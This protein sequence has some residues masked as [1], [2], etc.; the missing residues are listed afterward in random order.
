MKHFQIPGYADVSLQNRQYFDFYK[1][2]LGS[3]PNL[4]AML[5]HSDTGLDAYL[6]FHDHKQSLTIPEKEIIG[7][8]VGTVNQSVYCLETHVM[9]AR[10]NGFTDE[11]IREVKG[12]SARFNERYHALAQ[13][14]FNIM[15]TKGHPAS[16]QLEV[17]FEA[18]YTNESLVD[19]MLCIGDNMITN[20]LSCTMQVPS[21]FSPGQV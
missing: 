2:Q 3:L 10:L 12:G 17:F 20:L 14:V 1:K 18:G 7:L 4:Y 16:T 5:A 8:I 19:V 11:E 13:L 21:D 6:R 9:I 15:S